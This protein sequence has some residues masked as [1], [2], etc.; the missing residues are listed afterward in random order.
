MK[1]LYGTSAV[2][3]FRVAEQ[4]GN[5]EKQDFLIVCSGVTT[6]NFWLISKYFI[7]LKWRIFSSN[8][9]FWMSL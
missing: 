6:S 9:M 3:L 7:L 5:I 4:S 8:L 2:M 1:K